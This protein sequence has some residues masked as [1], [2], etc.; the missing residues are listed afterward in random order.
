MYIKKYSIQIVSSSTLL[1][2][3]IYLA[4]CLRDFFVGCIIY[5]QIL[6]IFCFVLFLIMVR[7][8]KR[9]D[10]FM[11]YSTEKSVTQVLNIFKLNPTYLKA[12]PQYFPD[13]NTRNNYP[14]SFH[15]NVYNSLIFQMK[16][17][18]SL[19]LHEKTQPYKNKTKTE[20]T[21]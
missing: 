6:V 19:R 3:S 18:F 4:N 1:T 7:R 14:K 11:D 2:T 12:F 16:H 21:R 8:P 15:S 9:E 5:M 17:I 10:G 13:I 20:T